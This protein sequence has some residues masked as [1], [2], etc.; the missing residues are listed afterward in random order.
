METFSKA[1]WLRYIDSGEDYYELPSLKS[2]DNMVNPRQSP[3]QLADVE[4]NAIVAL[5]VD[6][7]RMEVVPNIDNGWDFEGAV[8]VDEVER[9]RLKR[10]FRDLLESCRLKR[11]KEQSTVAEA[12][13]LDDKFVKQG[14]ESGAQM[15]NDATPVMQSTVESEAISLSASLENA[16]EEAA[17]AKLD[18]DAFRSNTGLNS[19]E[20]NVALAKVREVRQKEVEAWQSTK[21]RSEATLPKVYDE[22]SAEVKELRAHRDSAAAR[23][24]ELLAAVREKR[25]D[26]ATDT[27]VKLSKTYDESRKVTTEALMVQ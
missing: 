17:S 27:L 26:K 3:G 15:A 13:E 22:T 12:V 6:E 8:G 5:N 9:P 24:F 10:H 7:S 23:H 20:N 14:G 4:V 1:A 16:G 19:K 21:L 2:E 25:N 18:L 11:R